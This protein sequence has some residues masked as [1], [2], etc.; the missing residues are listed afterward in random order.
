MKEKIVRIEKCKVDSENPRE[1]H[2][3]LT[4]L[5]TT[6]SKGG[7]LEPVEGYKEET[8]EGNDKPSN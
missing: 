3:D 4:S 8:R 5:R 1:N 7:L 6:I 2:G